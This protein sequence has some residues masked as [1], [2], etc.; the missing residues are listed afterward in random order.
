MGQ[1]MFHS[2]TKLSVNCLRNVKLDVK[3]LNVPKISGSEN[4]SVLKVNLFVE[5]WDF[6]GT[7][8]GHPR[9][10]EEQ[11]QIQACQKLLSP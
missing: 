5:Q 1:M 9:T 10:R 7:E 2:D 8:L 11:T 3:P 6:S 4:G